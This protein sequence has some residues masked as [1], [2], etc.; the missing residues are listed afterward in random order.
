MPDHP[1][2]RLGL[3]AVVLAV[4]I[5][6]CTTS[7]AGTAIP[8]DTITEVARP[9]ATTTRRADRPRELKLDNIRP[10]ELLTPAQRQELKIDQPF[11]ELTEYN[12]NAPV[13]D[14]HSNPETASIV[15]VVLLDRD[16]DFFAPGKLAAE[17]RAIRVLGFPAFEAHVKQGK[18]GNEGCSV[19]V[20]VADGQVLRTQ[21]VEQGRYKDP[22]SHEELCRRA[23]RNAEIAVGNLL[24]RG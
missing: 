17:T 2:R 3:I 15:F 19:N 12:F 6:G 11:K 24:A 14:F 7:Q 5:T 22:L 9:A 18:P 1:V 4:A 10:C 23:T 8:Q 20:G 21:Y 16:A 13:C